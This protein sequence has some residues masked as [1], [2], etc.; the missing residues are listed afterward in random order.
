MQEGSLT[1]ITLSFLRFLERLGTPFARQRNHFSNKARKA[2]TLSGSKLLRS[3]LHCNQVMILLR[4]ATA[5]MLQK[6]TQLV[7]LP[8]I[9][10]RSTMTMLDLVIPFSQCT[11][12]CTQQCT[13]VLIRE[14]HTLVNPHLRW[15]SY[16]GQT[17][18]R[19]LILI[20]LQPF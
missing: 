9:L 4:E 18:L 13:M 12:Q 5:F 3:L 11:Q 1:H 19:M 7:P 10:L 2:K 14:V 15:S 17:R 20:Y 8:S 6:L 16:A